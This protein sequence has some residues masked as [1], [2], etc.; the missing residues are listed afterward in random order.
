MQDIAA[1]SLPN[2]QLLQ[3]AALCQRDAGHHSLLCQT[4]QGGDSFGDGLVSNSSA[5]VEIGGLF[6][7]TTPAAAFT[8]LGE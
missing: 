4:S 7:K 5:S 2:V 3:Q 6:R 8:A 1:F